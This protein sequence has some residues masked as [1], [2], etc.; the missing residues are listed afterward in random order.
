M[1]VREATKPRATRIPKIHI[2]KVV[3]GEN[4]RLIRTTSRGKASRHCIMTVSAAI[5]T[6]DELV[7]LLGQNVEVEEV[8]E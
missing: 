6:Q 4:T 8:G 2:Y 3:V 5:A 7:D 1:P